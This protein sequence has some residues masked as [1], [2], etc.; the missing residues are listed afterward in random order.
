M[1]MKRR[2]WPLMAVPAIIAMLIAA[3][4]P[5][6]D[7]RKGPEDTTPQIYTISVTPSS[8]GSITA[9]PT[10]AEAGSVITLTL[11]PAEGYALS[12]RTL[13]VTPQASGMSVS[14]SGSG[15]TRTFNMPASNVTVS[16]EF[17]VIS[18]FAGIDY[19]PVDNIEEINLT[20]TQG[21]LVLGS[22]ATTTVTAPDDYDFYYW[23]IDGE[24]FGNGANMYSVIIPATNP[25]VAFVGS[26]TVTVVV[27]RGGIFFSG[28]ASFNVVWL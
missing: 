22:T 26:H 12:Q 25:Y 4:C 6:D 11:S 13:I 23:F 15:P 18:G 28:N 1:K 16:G 17:G 8:N 27:Q 14:V 3:G 24:P 21:T 19:V 9:D 10:S 5:D 7:R 20:I 2:N